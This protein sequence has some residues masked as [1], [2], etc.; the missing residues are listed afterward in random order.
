MRPDRF[1]LVVLTDGL[2]RYILAGDGDHFWQQVPGQP[3]QDVPAKSV[4]TRRYMAE[5]MDPLFADE[6]YAFERLADGEAGGKVAYRIAVKRADSSSYVAVIDAATFREVAREDTDKSVTRYTD[7]RPVA[8]VTLAFRE[9]ITDAQGRHGVLDLTRITPN[10]GLI[11]AFFEPPPTQ[12]L[13]Y[14]AVERLMSPGG[15]PEK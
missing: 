8:G 1:R 6:G 5:F 13:D 9:E 2:T 14:F 10:P 7:F 11:R 4:G 3:P 12:G 15:Q